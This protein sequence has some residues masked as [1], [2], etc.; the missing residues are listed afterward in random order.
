MTSTAIQLPNIPA[1]DQSLWDNRLNELTNQFG[2]ASRSEINRLVFDCT[3]AFTTMEEQGKQLSDKKGLR[4]FFGTL[5]GSN[6]K[7]QNSINQSN[8]VFQYAAAQLLNKL[9]QRQAVGMEISVMLKNK[10][11]ALDREH[12]LQE[13]KLAMAAAR[14]AQH[15]EEMRQGLANFFTE[16]C[17]QSQRV[18]DRLDKLEANQTLMSWAMTVPDRTFGNE[19]YEDLEP[20]PLMLCLARDFYDLTEGN[21]KNDDLL[22]LRSAL[23]SLG[24]RPK[25][26]FDGWSFIKQIGGQP[27]L[28]E[29]MLGDYSFQSMPEEEYLSILGGIQK[30]NLLENEESYQVD[31]LLE[32][33]GGSLPVQAVRENLTQIFM[34]KQYGVDPELPVSWGD[35]LMILLFEL[36][37]AADEGIFVNDGHQ[38]ANRLETSAQNSDPEAQF[39]MG[40]KYEDGDGVEKDMEQAIFWY[41]KTAEQ[42]HAEAQYRLGNIYSLYDDDEYNDDNDNNNNKEKAVFWYTKAAEQGHAEAQFQMGKWYENDD[43]SLQNYLVAKLWYEKAANQ[44]HAESQYNLGNIYRYG[45]GIPQEYSKAAYWYQ[46]AAEQDYM[47]A[48]YN[49]G[50]MYYYGYG[51][52]KDIEQAIFWYEKAANQGYANASYN[53]AKIY[54]YGFDVEIDHE[55]CFFWYKKAAKQGH[56]EAQYEVGSFYDIVDIGVEANDEKADYWYQKA[57]EQGHVYAQYT[58]GVHY[59]FGF[60]GVNLDDSMAVFWY[61]Q[62]AN[63]GYASA[64][65]ELGVMYKLGQG[66]SPNRDTAIDW[67]KKAANQGHKKAIDELKDM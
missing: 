50:E 42:G 19:F 44:G 67:L 63:R 14:N 47:E 7:L 35:F 62:A 18:N 59:S 22:I 60:M 40:K 39:Q 20:E 36:R 34:K 17:E 41:T 45:R 3:S 10:M 26:P 15:L 24:I 5:T 23:R 65:Y 6:Q 21:W 27:E 64:Q 2:N 37:Q 13:Q 9:M 28:R 33:L 56:M 30:M 51:M 1:E 16:Y 58:L 46:Q 12:T 31:S 54:N 48:Q 66:V 38:T 52:K 29:K 57:A 32:M 53:L 4:R 43:S 49:L 11:E 25:T 55:E 61:S 8:Q